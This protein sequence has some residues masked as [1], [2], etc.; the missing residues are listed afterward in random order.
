MAATDELQCFWGRKNLCRKLIKFYNHFPRD[1]EMC[2]DF[3]KVMRK[4]KMAAMHELHN[5]CGRK[6][7]KIEVRNNV[8][9]GDFTDI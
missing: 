8:P 9:A 4:F 3:F 6:N 1:M 5:F 7:S 2:M